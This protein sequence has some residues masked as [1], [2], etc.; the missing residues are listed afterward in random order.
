MRDLLRLVGLVRPHWRLALLGLFLSLAALL[1]NLGL[2]ALSSWFIASMALAGLAGAVFDYTT[3]GAGVR[4]LALGRA[5]GRYAERLVNHDVTFRILSALRVWFY[6]RIEPLAPAR[7]SSY[8]SGDLLSRIRADI[9]TLD[10]FYVRGVVPSI[11]A[12][13]AVACILPFLAHFDARL[14]ALDAA[15]LAFAGVLLPLLLRRLSARPGRERVAW[16]AELRASIVEEVQG[17]A[18]LVALGAAEA[19]AGGVE[20]AGREMD[21]RQRTLASLQGLGDAGIVAASAVAVWAAAFVLAPVVAGGGLPRADMA[22]LTVLVLAS[23]ETIMPLPGVMQRAG[24]MAAAARRLFQIIDTEPAVRE[25]AATE[26][27]AEA[28]AAPAWL[29]AGEGAPGPV[30]ISVRDLRFRYSPELP[31]AIDGLS[32]DL[33]AGARIG[34]MGPTGAGK[35]SIVNVLLRFWD[36]QAGSIR[37]RGTDAVEYDL[38]SIP[39]EDARRLFSVVQQAPYLFH[40]SIREN[41]VIALPSPSNSAAPLREEAL[42]SALQTAQ[43][44]ELV[45]SLPDGLDTVVGETGREVSTGEIQRIAVARALL[46]DAPVYILDEPTEGLD[47][48]TA[49]MLLDAVARRL[50][51]RTLVVITHRERELAIVDS[52]F[53]LGGIQNDPGGVVTLHER[54]AGHENKSAPVR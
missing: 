48:S 45:A 53:R 25:P 41:L 18:E 6:E 30:S 38:R 9:D 23:F 10:D 15:G 54:N 14:A 34:I 16:A 8:R 7:L 46:R 49:G 47:D 13:L 21:R 27:G 43:L 35:S 44:T 37:V 52:I 29:P 32:I 20:A 4:A 28:P 36:F 51:G 50:R 19:H 33:T 1:A 17:M 22:M 3:A 5:A 39:T 26:P 11:V 40:A 24:E 31:W 12:V 42:R 2:L